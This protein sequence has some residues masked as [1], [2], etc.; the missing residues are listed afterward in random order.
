MCIVAAETILVNFCGCLTLL[1]RFGKTVRTANLA[2]A[3]RLGT[4][5]GLDSMFQHELG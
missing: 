4:T 2:N 5:T 3:G 1:N